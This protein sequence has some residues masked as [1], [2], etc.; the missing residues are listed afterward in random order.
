MSVDEGKR[1]HTAQRA[2]AFPRVVRHPAALRI[3][4]G[5]PDRKLMG[6][7]YRLMA[8]RGI[9]RIFQCG[10]HS[11]QDVGIGLAPAR[12]ERVSKIEPVLR[13]TQGAIKR[14]PQ[15]L[16]IV[17]RFDQP[18]IDDDRQ[19]ERFGDGC[20]RLLRPL[21]R[22]ASEMYDVTVAE[23]FGNSLSHLPAQLRKVVVGQA[24][25]KQPRRVVHLTVSYE[26]HNRAV[27]THAGLA[28]IPRRPRRHPPQ[29]VALRRSDST[30]YHHAPPTETK[31]R[32]RSA[33]NTRRR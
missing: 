13:M 3:G 11:G 15:P 18:A 27:L 4:T 2:L 33:A 30:L 12:P 22:R 24:P 23:M 25:V 9:G 7:D 19:T 10:A 5:D 6:D 28:S 16:E 20:G 8:Q 1:R 21:Q 29:L 26:V 17:R 14:K 32:T 31:L